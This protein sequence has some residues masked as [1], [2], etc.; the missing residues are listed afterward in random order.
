MDE[1]I[2]ALL[3][4]HPF[5]PF[6]VVLT[7]GRAEDVTDRELAEMRPEGAVTLFVRPPGRPNGRIT[8]AI[9][10]TAHVALIEMDP[11]GET[12]RVRP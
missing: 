2:R 4:A 3:A 8:K 12:S 5:V 11:A 9:V 10:S 6:R 7:S 1:V